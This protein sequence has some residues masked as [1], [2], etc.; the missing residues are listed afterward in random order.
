VIALDALNLNIFTDKRHKFLIEAIL[1][2]EK[3][4][5]EVA[6]EEG[7]SVREV[8][9]RFNTACNKLIQYHETQQRQFNEEKL[10]KQHPR[11]ILGVKRKP[12]FIKRV[13]ITFN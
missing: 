6:A 2:E 10:K 13:P 4:L 9:S 1:F 3:S 7:L 5:E 8:K 11:F 12:I